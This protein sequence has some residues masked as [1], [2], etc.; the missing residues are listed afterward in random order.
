M[1]SLGAQLFSNDIDDISVLKG[2][3]ATALYGVR[4]K[5]GVVIITTKKGLESVT[6]VEARSDLKETAFFFPHLKTNRNGEVI[7]S[8]DSPQALTK[9]RLMLLAHNKSVEVGSMEKTVVT[10]KDLS[11]IPNPPRFLRE[12]DTLFLS[13]KISNLTKQPLVGSALLQMFNGVTSAPISTSIILSDSYQ[14]FTIPSNGNTS[15]SWKLQIP[16]GI[17]ALEYKIVAKSGSHSDGEANILPVLSSRTLV[18]E[19]KPLWLAKGTTKE[20]VFEKLKTP[21]SASLKN[22]S[23]T[24]EYTSNP[25]W[26]ALKSLPYLIEFPYDCA[27]QT[28]SRFYANALAEDILAQNPQIKNVLKIWR[29]NGQ[30]KSALELNESLKSVLVSE[31]PWVRDLGS[32][33]ENKTRLA[34]LLD[35]QNLQEGQLQALA[36]LKQ[37]QLPSG[38]FPWFAG[39]VENTFITRYIVAGI[40]HLE[41]LNVKG[42]SDYKL[43]PL[44]KKAIAYLDDQFV[45]DYQS[46]LKSKEDSTG[47]NLDH[48]IV[49]YLYARSF[50]FKSHPL[51]EKT[52]KII[53]L[54]IEKCKSSWLSQSLYNKGMIA[55]IMKRNGFEK[56]AKNIVDSLEEQAVQSDENGWYW[57]ENTNSWYWYKSA[58]ETQVLL[59]EA[60]TE[61]SQDIEK[62]DKLKQWLLKNKQTNR[63]GSTKATTEAI[64]ALLMHGNNWL[65]VMEN[66]I[67]TIGNEKIKNKKLD[68]VKKEAGTGYL[69]VNWKGKEISSRIASVNV[70]YKS[71]ITG[72]GGVYWQ[73]SEDLDKVSATKNIPLNIKKLLFIKNTGDDGEKLTPIG[74]DMPI[75]IGDIVTIRIEV[76]S[77][78]DME[79]IHL[80]DMRASGLEP[81]EVLSNYKWQDGLGYYQSTRDV[82]THFF[83]DKLPK[84]TYV[85]EYDLQAN[86]K[87][88]FSNGI[89]TIQSMY[90][91]EFSGNSKGVRLK[92]E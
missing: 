24:L 14:C 65:S 49:H 26:L 57:K 74:R 60:F 19:T 31:S 66:T 13:A 22:H 89:T 42:E 45:N 83:F 63:W 47:V 20:V 81:V 88:D 69:K 71:D 40:G 90:A 37:L 15:V 87:G 62:A 54:Y 50:F 85:F 92:I 59:I 75:K 35:L 58:I 67:I 51:T 79:F 28:F 38:G 72:F 17:P 64:Y 43:K 78:N 56:E 34:K 84:G 18:T 91:P 23:F 7:F 5:N 3:G 70:Q 12:N 82:A 52:N 33:Q 32:D 77:K 29:S 10:Q 6:Q 48:N 9:W 16:E 46:R 2:A 8:F 53:N 73:Y 21:T 44:L 76:T 1:D 39:G 4:A 41:K 11:V 55:L 86:N 68:S 25:T 80:K 30:L 36:N 61:I 27:E